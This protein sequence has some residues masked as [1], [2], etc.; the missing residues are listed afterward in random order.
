ME[1]IIGMAVIAATRLAGV[2]I[3]L[4][5]H[6]NVHNY[7]EENYVLFSAV[8]SKDRGSIGR[9]RCCKIACNTH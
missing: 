6:S 2:S 8:W 9:N 3:I 4:V 7:K 1:V 5:V